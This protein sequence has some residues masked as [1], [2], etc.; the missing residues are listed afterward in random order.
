[1]ETILRFKGNVD[2]DIFPNY[3]NIDYRPFIL[4]TIFGHIGVL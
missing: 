4:I 2:L 3:K 1:M